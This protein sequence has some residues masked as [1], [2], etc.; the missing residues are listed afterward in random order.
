MRMRNHFRE[1]DIVSA[2]VS[3]RYTTTQIAQAF[4]MS[5]RHVVRICSWHGVNRSQKEGNRVA[6]P[7]KSRYRISRR[8]TFDV[9]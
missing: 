1:L 7:L 6:A 4:G 2:Y 9:Y 3:K 5:R 8:M